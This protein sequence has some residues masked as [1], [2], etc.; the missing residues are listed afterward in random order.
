VA[1]DLS[2]MSTQVQYDFLIQGKYSL[3]KPRKRAAH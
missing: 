3:G 2:H 1:L